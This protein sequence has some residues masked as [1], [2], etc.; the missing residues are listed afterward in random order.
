MSW[1]LGPFSAAFKKP[2]ISIL[3]RSF[4]GV[5]L[6][7]T[8]WASSDGRLS[9]ASGN[10]KSRGWLPKPVSRAVHAGRSTFLA[11]VRRARRGVT[12]VRVRVSLLP[13]TGPSVSNWSRAAQARTI[14]SCANGIVPTYATGEA[15]TSAT[16]TVDSSWR[17]LRRPSLGTHGYFARVN[18]S[19]WS[20]SMTVKASAVRWLDPLSDLYNLG[21]Y[22]RGGATRG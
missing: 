17:W 16:G 2:T 5:R 12:N 7:L 11:R 10:R 4:K 8:V 14:P 3:R 22:T 19:K 18:K 21:T 15:P 9:I 1:S 20:T 13:T 6:R